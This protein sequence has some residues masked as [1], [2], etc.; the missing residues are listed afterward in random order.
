MANLSGLLSGETAGENR[1]IPDE[2][3]ELLMKDDRISF[4]DELI[5]TNGSSKA[6]HGIVHR[7]GQVYI[8]LFY[9]V[10]SPGYGECILYD[11]EE[12]HQTPRKYDNA[13]KIN[14]NP[15]IVAAYL[16]SL[17]DCFCHICRESHLQA[18]MLTPK[19]FISSHLLQ[20]MDMYEHKL[21]ERYCDR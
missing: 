6:D 18:R 5:M 9:G 3:I 15:E 14:E 1:M 10:R 17:T 8:E 7:T 16:K 12:E 19:L 13:D 2:S 11:I 4:F 21:R 20:Y